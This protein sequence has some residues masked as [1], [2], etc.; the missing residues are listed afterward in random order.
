[1]RYSEVQFN[2]DVAYYKRM[3]KKRLG[4]G[5]TCLVS[6]PLEN[7]SAFFSLAPLSRAVDEFGSDLSVFVLGK[8]SSTLPVLRK[9]WELYS[10]L[11]K[12]GKSNAAKAMQ[13][14]IESVQR[15]TK[16][17]YFEKLF[18]QPDLEINVKTK[19]FG[20]DSK[21]ID[22]RTGWFRRSKWKQL[23]ATNKRILQQGYGLRKA[24]R[25]SIGFELIP[26]KKSLEL[27]LQDY[28]DSFSIAYTFALAGKAMCKSVSMGAE[29]ARM[30]QLEPMGRVSDL[31]S[32]LVGCEY[33][34]NISE[35][36]FNA[37]KRLSPFI[38]AS[39]LNPSNA[40]F[41][42]HGKGYGGK[43]F[44]GMKI[45]YPSPN[46][47]TRWQGPGQMFLKPWWAE[48][49]KIDK[50]PARTRYAITETLPLENY[51]RSCYVDYFKMR[52]KADRIRDVLRK[53]KALFV[54]G[55]RVKGGRTSL[56]LDLSHI[57]SKKSPVLSSDIEVNPKTPREAAK[58]F[59]TNS[60]RYGNFPGGEVFFTPH[61]MDGTFIGDVVINVDQSYVIPENKPL[62]V[63]VKAGK[64]R[65]L[66]GSGTILKAF[67]KRKKESMGMIR[68]FE[69]NRSMPKKIISS[70]KRNF[71]NVGEF[72]I[73]T[74]PKARLSRYLIETEKLARM[75]HI[76]L[77]SGYEPGRQ[78]TYHCDIVINSPRQKLD[79]YAIDKAG[80]QLWIIK[81]GKM[82]V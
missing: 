47:K 56:R 14:F 41:G 46:R 20:F 77:G 70:M 24:E 12:G 10:Q 54:E 68:I 71:S 57:L 32:T 9:T 15:K 1:M 4:K 66:S 50:R 6:L 22:F 3:L 48:Q 65:V 21:L 17:S 16:D 53:S 59:K 34:K 29:T 38:G 26:K 33:E 11:K 81:K 18:R 82:V 55:Q 79:I 43:H 62:V 19:G 72:A 35:P 40:S 45:G 69:K 44:F 5:K 7:E 61:R 60:G 31:S 75:I 36:W 37:F 25:L 58:I 64:Y 39:K 73:N 49:S 63:S 76:A 74:N 42:I 30:S 78:T 80:N 27:P 28:L 67:N 2:K 13:A 51:I 23:L 52:E 8:E